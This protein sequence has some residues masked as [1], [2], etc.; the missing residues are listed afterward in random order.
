METATIDSCVNPFED[1]VYI[2]FE[3]SLARNPDSWM[4]LKSPNLGLLWAGPTQ[5]FKE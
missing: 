3:S 5:A 1:I 4:N 2:D